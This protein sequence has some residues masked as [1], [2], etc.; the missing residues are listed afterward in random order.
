MA[1]WLIG[2]YGII[3]GVKIYRVNGNKSDLE[4][5]ID[6]VRKEGGKFDDT[7]EIHH[8]RKDEYTLLI[9]LKVAVTSNM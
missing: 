5:I 3:N 8:I 9:K 7:P 4:R 2:D 6:E 1:I